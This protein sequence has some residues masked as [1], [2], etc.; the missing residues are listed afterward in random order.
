VFYAIAL[1]LITNIASIGWLY[2]AFDTLT[3]DR[4]TDNR[5]AH[6]TFLTMFLDRVTPNSRLLRVTVKK[7]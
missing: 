6:N 1:Y 3:A 7:P 5:L 4:T 2:R